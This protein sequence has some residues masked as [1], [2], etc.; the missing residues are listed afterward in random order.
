VALIKESYIN[1][2][3]L[4]NVVLFIA[5]VG[6]WFCLN[7]DLAI[8]D[9]NPTILGVMYFYYLPSS[10]ILSPEKNERRGRRRASGNKDEMENRK[11]H[12][13]VCTFFFRR[14]KEFSLLVFPSLRW[15]YSLGP[16]SLFLESNTLLPISASI[17]LST[18]SL[19]ACLHLLLGHTLQRRFLQWS[20]VS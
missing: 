2:A 9:L 4:C 20:L 12:I 18:I 14:W 11:T 15:F 1:V 3:F 6:V 8:V 19:L 17:S 5:L 16:P 7:L 10:F 13:V